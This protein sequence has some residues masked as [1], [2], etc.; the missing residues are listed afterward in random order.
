LNAKNIIVKNSKS[1]KFENPILYNLK[2]KNNKNANS[3]C[4]TFEF[5]H[6]YLAAFG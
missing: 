6:T 1:S 5:D 2:R 3:F 4:S